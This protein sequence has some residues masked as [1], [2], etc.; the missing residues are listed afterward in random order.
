MCGDV[1]NVWIPWGLKSELMGVRYGL[2]R[3]LGHRLSPK[4][5]IYARITGVLAGHSPSHAYQ[6]MR[7][8]ESFQD[9]VE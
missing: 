7:L 3:A 5:H 8:D 1:G 2:K 4:T 6:Q 9:L